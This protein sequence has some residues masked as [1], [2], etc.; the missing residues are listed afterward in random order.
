MFFFS[1]AVLNPELVSHP[2]NYTQAEPSITPKHIV[3][4]WYF[5]PMYGIL[6]LMPDKVLGMFI[7]ILAI[8]WFVIISSY[9]YNTKL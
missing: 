7:M 6:R 2:D 9:S 4:E 8:L 1:V 5:L 3:P